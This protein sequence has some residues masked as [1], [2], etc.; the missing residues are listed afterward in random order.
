VAWRGQGGSAAGLF[1]IGPGGTRA[2]S[3]PSLDI[4]A[5]PAVAK[6]GTVYAGDTLGKLHA[7][8][9]GTGSERWTA[10]L[11]GDTTEVW[12]TPTVGPDGMVYLGTTS[13]MTAGTASG[14]P[15]ITTF[16]AVKPDGSFLWAHA[17]NALG[18]PI[19]GSP[20]LG[21]DGTV[22]VL[23]PDLALNAITPSGH[24]L[25]TVPTNG[26]EQLNPG[27]GPI[28]DGDGVAYVVTTELQFTTSML[29]AVTRSGE[30]AWTMALD[31]FANGPPAIGA[32][33]T[34]YVATSAALYAIGGT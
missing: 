1:A 7:L 19:S 5:S 25:W 4:V 14:D 16:Y 32:D 11:G 12:M 26:V 30:I 21:I 3:A 15:V 18:Y 33:G 31:G 13:G 17:F 34:L 23:G 10:D 20:A 22:Y 6:D 2:W 9:P 27:Y 24:I 8:D 29:Y 28:L